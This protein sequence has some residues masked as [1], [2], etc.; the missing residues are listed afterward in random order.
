[1]GSLIVAWWLAVAPPQYDL[2]MMQQSYKPIANAVYVPK[3]KR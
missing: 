2:L 3:R 1:M